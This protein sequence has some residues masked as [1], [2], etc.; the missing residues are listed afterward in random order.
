MASALARGVISKRPD[1]T[2]PHRPLVDALRKLG[3]SFEMAHIFGVGSLETHVDDVT[4]GGSE[5]VHYHLPITDIRSTAR[6]PNGTRFDEIMAGIGKG[7]DDDFYYSD[8]KRAAEWIMENPS[9]HLRRA[10][11]QEEE[12]TFRGF[13]LEVSLALVIDQLREDE[14]VL[15]N[16][17]HVKVR[18]LREYYVDGRFPSD[19]P[20]RP[21]SVPVLSAKIGPYELTQVFGPTWAD[22]MQKLMGMMGQAYFSTIA[23]ISR[24]WTTGIVMDITGDI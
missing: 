20:L 22:R 3:L 14:S 4:C 5:N 11:L 21:S 19:R 10:M 9:M 23:G 6:D 18:T 13:P 12:V 16:A 8:A 15:P 1:G 24:L 7:P 17:M 2:I